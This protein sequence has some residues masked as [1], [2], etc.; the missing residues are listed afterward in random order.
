[1]WSGTQ[2]IGIH[3]LDSLELFNKPN[4]PQATGWQRIDNTG[5]IKLFL[6][7]YIKKGLTLFFEQVD[8][9][10]H[11]QDRE[12][13]VEDLYWVVKDLVLDQLVVL[14]LLYVLGVNLGFALNEQLL[15]TLL[16]DSLALIVYLVLL[17]F[18]DRWVCLISCWT[19]NPF[20]ILQF[21]YYFY[22][23]P[24]Y[25]IYFIKE[26]S[27]HHFLLYLDNH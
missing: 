13:P 2:V 23:H 5:T 1:M 3:D 6:F 7:F 21:L 9:R 17:H 11:D 15:V 16:D 8:I 4:G 18:V 19:K 25:L 10:L 24:S 14:V 26:I 22:N 27:L 20:C 12:V